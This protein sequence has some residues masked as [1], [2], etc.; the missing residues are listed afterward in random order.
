MPDDLYQKRDQ[1]LGE[2][3][4]GVQNLEEWCKAHEQK[5]DERFKEIDRKLLWGAFALI[6]IAFSTGVLGQLIGHVKIG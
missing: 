3:H 4:K 1:M 5:D 6:I 2:I